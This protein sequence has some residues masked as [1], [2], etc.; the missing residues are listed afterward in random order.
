MKTTI[1][2]IALALATMPLTFAAQTPAPAA[3]ATTSKPAVAAP[4]KT[5]KTAKKH[6]KKGVKKTVKTARATATPAP[7]KQ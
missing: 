4:A 5:T 7:V 3:P 2:T 1:L 6:H